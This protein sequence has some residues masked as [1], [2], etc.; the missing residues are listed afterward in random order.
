MLK[1]YSMRQETLD[2][3]KKLQRLFEE[4]GAMLSTAESCTGG[5]ISHYITFI[6]GASPWFN[7]GMVTYSEEMKRNV[8][9]VSP[10]T[11]GDHG[12]VSEAVAREMAERA[13][14]LSGSDYSVSSTGNLGPDV[15]EG[16][17]KGLVY[18][19]ASGKGKTVSRELHLDGD[20]KA[21]KE[22]AVFEALKLLLEFVE[23]DGP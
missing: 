1:S 8:L 17:E 20:R 6:A 12:V 11:I 7:G 22:E 4:K 13:V 9:G 10:K 21:N 15:L 19:A 3:I 23:E 18:I 16:K 2:I 14:S 5:L